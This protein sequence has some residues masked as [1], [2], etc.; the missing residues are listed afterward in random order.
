MASRGFRSQKSAAMLYDRAAMPSCEI[1]KT[2][3]LNFTVSTMTARCWFVPMGSWLGAKRTAPARNRAKS[4]KSC[5]ACLLT[6]SHTH[7]EQP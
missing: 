7:Y 4:N 5:A 2:N 6:E 3:F 1:R